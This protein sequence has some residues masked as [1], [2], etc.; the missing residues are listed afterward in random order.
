[1]KSQYGFKW[2]GYANEGKWQTDKH[3]VVCFRDKQ[4]RARLKLACGNFSFYRPNG[5]ETDLETFVDEVLAFNTDD[6]DDDLS[7]LGKS[8]VPPFTPGEKRQR[9]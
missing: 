9:S 2:R 1:M 3:A 6:V 4:F 8:S 5:E 7:T